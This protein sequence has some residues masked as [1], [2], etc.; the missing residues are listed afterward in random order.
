MSPKEISQF[1]KSVW[2]ELE[3]VVWPSKKELIYY[4]TIVLV[5]I[6]ISMI[7]IAFIDLGLSKI[8]ESLIYKE[9]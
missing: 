2:L 9:R 6:L 4:L 8:L 5:T 7:I 1:F 3:K